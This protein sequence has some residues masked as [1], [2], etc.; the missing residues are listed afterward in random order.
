MVN[1][2]GLWRDPDSTPYSQHDESQGTSGSE[3]FR[4][5]RTRS[6]IPEGW[7]RLKTEKRGRAQGDLVWQDNRLELNYKPTLAE[8]LSRVGLVLGMVGRLSSKDLQPNTH[9]CLRIWDGTCS[10]PELHTRCFR[11]TGGAGLI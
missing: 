7:R 2:A 11:G 8:V 6:L 9:L 4:Q 10:V 3:L 5:I 1:F